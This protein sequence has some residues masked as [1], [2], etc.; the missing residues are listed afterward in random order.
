MAYS[1]IVLTTSLLLVEGL[2]ADRKDV[3]TVWLENNEVRFSH[4][5]SLLF[6]QVM[7]QIAFWAYLPQMES[8]YEVTIGTITFHS[9]SWHI[10]CTTDTV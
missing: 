6:F 9:C 5:D 3:E 2:V 10:S 1:L 4:F 8:I 7:A